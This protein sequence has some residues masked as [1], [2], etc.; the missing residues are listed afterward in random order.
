MATEA[1]PEPGPKRS[2]GTPRKDRVVAPDGTGDSGQS[3]WRAANVV[4][5]AETLVLPQVP[6]VAS[7]RSSPRL[8]GGA[9]PR[10]SRGGVVKQVAPE[11][12]VVVGTGRQQLASFGHEVGVVGEEAF[13]MIDC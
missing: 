12:V 4:R 10:L 1:D 3:W 6:A 9:Q 2:G 13:R 7:P 5:V 8:L 11:D